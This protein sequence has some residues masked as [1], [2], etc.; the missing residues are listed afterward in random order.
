MLD[1]ETQIRLL[2]LIKS[3]DFMKRTGWNT[4]CTTGAEQFESPESVKNI[5]KNLKIY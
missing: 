5:E 2:N 3:T 4:V 1:R